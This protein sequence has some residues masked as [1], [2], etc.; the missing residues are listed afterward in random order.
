MGETPPQVQQQSREEDSGD[1]GWEHT[2]SSSLWGTRKSRRAEPQLTGA[3]PPRGYTTNT[4]RPLTF[5]EKFRRYIADLGGPNLEGKEEKG[6]DRR[7]GT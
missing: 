3:P 5:G 2:W 7:L 1:Q 6:M 4:T